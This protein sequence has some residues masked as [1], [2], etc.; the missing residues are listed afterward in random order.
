MTS[1]DK[2]LDDSTRPQVT[3]DLAEVA[4]AAIKNQS[5]I[6]GAAVKTALAGARKVDADIVSK[7]VNVLL[8]TIVETFAPHWDAFKADGSEGSFSAYLEPKSEEVANDLL[9]GADAVVAEHAKAGL[10]K[11]YNGLRGKGAKLLTPHI[12]AIGE[13]IERHA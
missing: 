6:T 1:L 11:I 10:D 2:L 12:T 5:G 4:E 13:V 8:P 7:G 3:A 9:D